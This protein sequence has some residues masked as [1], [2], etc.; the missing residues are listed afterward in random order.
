MIWVAEYFRS[1]ILTAGAFFALYLWAIFVIRIVLS[2]RYRPQPEPHE[3]NVSVVVPIFKETVEVVE[4]CLRSIAEQNP[5]E[6][7]VIINGDWHSRRE[8]ADCAIRYCDVLIILEPAN[9]RLAISVGVRNAK[10]EIV[11][12]VDSDTVIAE[13]GLSEIT[14]AFKDQLVGGATSKQSILIQNGAL[15]ERIANWIESMRFLVNQQAQSGFG[16]VGCL[17]G[18]FIAFRKSVIQ[19]HLDG[20]VSQKFLGVPCIS[21]DDRYLTSC[22]LKEGYRTVLQS[23]A[24][25]R[26]KCPATFPEFWKQQLRWARSSQ[27]ETILSLK[28]LHRYPYTFFCFVTDL[29]TPFFFL[30]A[31]SDTFYRI[32][33]LGGTLP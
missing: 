13:N 28:W 30:F 33:I 3:A 11:A 25:A 18:R 16:A 31:I 9:K 27:R 4:N 32:Y 7:F 24:E 5:D 12:L 20:L 29:V 6:F 8:V 21:G 17:P 19:G 2:K 10:N 14:K 22:V 23:S 15:I 1:G 26:T